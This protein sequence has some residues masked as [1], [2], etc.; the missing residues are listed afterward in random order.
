LSFVQKAVG[1]LVKIKAL[2]GGAW[3][4]VIIMDPEDEYRAYVL[5]DGAFRLQER[6]ELSMSQPLTEDIA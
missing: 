3:V 2:V 1:N 4:R 6:S 5:D